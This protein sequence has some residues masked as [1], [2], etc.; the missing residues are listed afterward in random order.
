MCLVRPLDQD[1]PSRGALPPSGY[2]SRCMYAL[3][4][5]LHHFIRLWGGADFLVR[6]PPFI[7]ALPPPFARSRPS[8]LFEL[9]D[10]SVNVSNAFLSA[11]VQRP[12]NLVIA[13]CHVIHL[14]LGCVTSRHSRTPRAANLRVPSVN[15]HPLPAV[16]YKVPTSHYHTKPGTDWR[17]LVRLHAE[18][19]AATSFNRNPFDRN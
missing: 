15:S 19:E 4:A 14:P 16:R 3:G 7:H 18:L 8:V 1:F 17:F 9:C 5:S 10:D 12:G 11:A 6:C 2:P 13:S